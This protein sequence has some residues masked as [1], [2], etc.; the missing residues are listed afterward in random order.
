VKSQKKEFQSSFGKINTENLDSLISNFETNILRQNYPKLDIKNAYKKFLKE[1][2]ENKMELND[3]LLLS[4]EKILQR[5]NLK[6]HIYNILDSVWVGKS[7]FSENIKEQLIFRYK[8]INTNG[9]FNYMYSE[10][11]KNDIKIKKD[12]AEKYKPINLNGLYIKS[13]EKASSKS[14]LLENYVENLNLSGSFIS[15]I[16]LASNI[17]NNEID[18]SNYFVKIII[19]TNIIYR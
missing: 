7:L 10:T 5:K 4:G 1:L 15:P 6:F 9:D 3:S 19:L 8:H 18:T 16:V 12:I 11:S 14:N 2:I 13:L 17:L